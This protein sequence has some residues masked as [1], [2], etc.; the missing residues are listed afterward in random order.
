MRLPDALR[1]MVEERAQL[2]C[3]L[4]EYG[5]FAGVVTGEDL[6]EEIVGE[7]EDEH[8]PAPPPAAEEGEPGS[9]TVPG[10]LHVDEVER[11]LDRELAD[12]EAETVGGLLIEAHG[13][14]PEVGTT[15][16]VEL[17][18]DPAAVLDDEEP[19][20]EQVRLEVLEVERH[21]PSVVRLTLE[22]RPE[23]AAETDTSTD[24]D[25]Q[26]SSLVEQEDHR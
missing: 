7:I 9:W 8:D 1:T 22:V 18:P 23:P 17:P 26:A 11:L 20:V 10:D 5:G 3:V 4:D 12:S 19:A 25:E 13:A 6:A 2:L 24:T 15:V 14:L 21:V 16:T